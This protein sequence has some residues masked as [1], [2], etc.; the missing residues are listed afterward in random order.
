MQTF[1]A[2]GLAKLLG[3]IDQAKGNIATLAA[4]GSADDTMEAEAIGLHISSIVSMALHHATAAKL[5]STYDRV[6]E[7]G[8]PFWMAMKTGQLT[9]GQAEHELIFLRQCIEADLERRFFAF[10]EPQHAQL[11]GTMDSNWGLIIAQIPD[12]KA[13]I[14]DAHISYMVEL[15]TF[16]RVSRDAG[17]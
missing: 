11:F 12:S 17:S 10:V 6:W 5:Q 9:Y 1:D 16:D 2:W 15:Y 4:M 7:G 14:E 3:H 13:D 8:G